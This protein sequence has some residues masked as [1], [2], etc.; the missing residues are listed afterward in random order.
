MVIPLLLKLKAL[1][2]R[3]REVHRIGNHEADAAADMGSRRVHCSITDTRRLANGTC[4]RWYPVVKEFQHFFVAIA[5]TV[6]NHDGSGGTSLHPT[7]WFGAANPKRRRVDRAVRDMAWLPGPASLCTSD[8]ECCPV[9]GVT[10][11]AIQAWPFSVGRLTK[12]LVVCIGL[13]VLVIWGLAVSLIL[14]CLSCMRDGLVSVWYLSRCCRM[15]KR[16]GVQFQCRLFLLAQALIY[17]ARAGLLV[18]FFGF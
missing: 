5:R 3:V 16:L 4:A 6:V 13:W 12:V 2:M 17:D 10:A 18:V 14:S 9:V 7:V 11:A 15:V 1:R 8:G